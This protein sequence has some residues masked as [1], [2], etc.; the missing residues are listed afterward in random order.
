MQTAPAELSEVLPDSGERGREVRRFGDVVEA[1]H[2]E[3]T[4]DL[5][6]RFV[7][8]T[9]QPKP[10]DLADGIS[11][12]LFTTIEGLAVA[13]PAMV[14]YSLLRNRV[15]RFVLEVGMISEGLMSRFSTVGKK[16]GGGSHQTAPAAKQE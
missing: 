15:A 13:I 8:S 4:W 1:D 9:Q 5:P 10:K 3:V 16:A 6:R 14:F 11:T 7:H 12:A 2:A